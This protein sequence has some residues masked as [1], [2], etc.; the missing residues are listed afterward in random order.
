[1]RV[2]VVKRA[3]DLDTTV[4]PHVRRISISNLKLT[5]DCVHRSVK[6]E[7][8]QKG[9]VVSCRQTDHLLKAVIQDKDTQSS[10]SSQHTSIGVIFFG[11]LAKDFSQTVSQGDIVLLS[12]FTISKSPTEQ[13]DE[14]H[15]CLLEMSST[16]ACVY[17]YS[18][19]V[20]VSSLP[21]VVS[22]ES[23]YTY[24]PLNELKPSRIVNVY[25]VV[26]FFK[27][28]F[29]TKGTDYCSTLKITD[30]SNVKVS[31]TIF[32]E[33]LEDHPKIFRIGDIIRLHRVKAQMFNGSMTLLTTLGWSTI[34]F[35]G[36]I[37]SPI[38]PRTSSRTFHFGEAD[39]HAVQELRQWAASQL[40]ANESTV[41][42]S[43]VHPKMFF[44][45]TCQLL[46]KARMDTRCMLLKVWDGTKCAHPLLNVAVA[47]DALEGQSSPS[48]DRE[49]MI[50]NVLVYDN[51]VEG[52]SKLKPGMFLRLFNLHAVTQRA[53]EQSAD[54]AS[55]LCFHL[56]GGTSYGKGLCVLPSESPELQPLKRLLEGHVAVAGEDEV[57]DATLVDVWYTPPEALGQFQPLHIRA[58]PSEVVNED[59]YTVRTCGHTL[60]KVSLAHVKSSTAP[61]VCH[62]RAK[63]KSYQ[64]Q[65]LYQCLKLFCPQC[66]TLMEVPNDEII[67]RVFQ[68][69]L[70]VNQ[71]CGEHWAVTSS[72][73]SIRMHVSCEMV[74]SN[75][76][77][78]LL[79]LQGVT[80][81]E[82]S[83]ISAAHSNVVPV[84]SDDERMRLLDFSAP[85]LFRR[86]KRYFGCKRC[87]RS[88]FVEPEVSGVEI[89]DE[90]NVAKALGVQLMQY[91][92]LMK[93]E[94][95][96][97]TGTLEAL[98]WEDAE[99]FFQV[100]AADTSAC[101]D[102]Q[103]K[104]QITMDR[105]HPPGS[106]MERPW[107]DLCL[108]AYTVEENSSNQVCYQITNTE[109]RGNFYTPQ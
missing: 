76:H 102:S 92:L 91:A 90:H 42:L 57:N 41:P 81:E 30:K 97:E 35:D 103:D 44:D 60:Q 13:T 19:N 11:T 52:A 27:Q 33:R 46:A 99:R 86:D 54:C 36:M 56:H 22:S 39:K 49:N 67:A 32:S 105:L 61:V 38:E 8:V 51:H 7:V 98:I 9:P 12:G 40:L 89:W 5:S 53:P 74:L 6:G 83:V 1:M 34:T 95:E 66:T 85:F 28:P 37:D 88:T 16:D 59:F 68:D 10:D 15:P 25:G 71:P 65:N 47:P 107:L 23:R 84:C 80:L 75:T 101:Q 78:Q 55:S 96:D 72:V 29:P 94:L 100:T 20:V 64:P 69:A 31:C 62:V 63:V 77:T 17:V 109:A 18:S 43:S 26:T 93:F 21:A 79:F 4:P 108:S 58:E 3:S 2:H 24:V 70:R 82:M 104:V 73:D 50:A 87:S 14:L 48:Q 45:L 106:S